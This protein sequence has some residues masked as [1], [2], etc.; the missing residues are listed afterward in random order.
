M[1]RDE[2]DRQCLTLTSSLPLPLS[3]TQ[4]FNPSLNDLPANKLCVLKL[5]LQ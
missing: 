4:H 3:F 2:R 5:L 1:E